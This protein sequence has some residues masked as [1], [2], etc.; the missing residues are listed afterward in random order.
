MH[1]PAASAMSILASSKAEQ[2]IDDDFARAF[3]R[4]VEEEV[5]RIAASKKKFKKTAERPAAESTVDAV[6]YSLRSG[7]AVL[8]R[9]DV[10]ARL[11]VI[12]E[13]QL[14]EMVVL[15]QK[16]DGRIAPRWEDDDIEKLL[17]TWMACHHG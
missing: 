13:D 2:A 12:A 6:M 16:H 17:E 7:T 8:A 15:L 5:A 10:R 9:D 11:A 1:A 14:R 4:K 3:D